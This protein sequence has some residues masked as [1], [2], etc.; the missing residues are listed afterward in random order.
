M[1]KIGIQDLIQLLG[2]AGIIGSLIFVGLEF[3]QSR[4]SPWR[5]SKW[6]EQRIDPIVLLRLMKRD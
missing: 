4:K 6:G 5:V 2:M 1:E 3:R